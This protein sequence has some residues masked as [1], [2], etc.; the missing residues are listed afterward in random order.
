MRC[1]SVSV[2]I[3]DYLDPY[4]STSEMRLRYAVGDAEAFHRYMSLGWPSGHNSRHVLLRDLA[5]VIGR[6]ETAVASV[7][8]DG[9]LDLFVLYLSGHGEVSADGSGWFCLDAQLRLPSLDCTTIDRCLAAVDAD[10]VVVFIDCCHAE[11]VVAGS[12]SFSIGK[13]RRARV[14]ATSC[15]ADQRARSC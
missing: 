5:A 7:C 3:V 14:V 2:G 12:Q 15:R 10:C 6:F 4:Y 8:A 9:P 11:A 13:G 1:A